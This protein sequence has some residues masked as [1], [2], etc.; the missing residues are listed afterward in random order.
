MDASSLKFRWRQY[1]NWLG[2]FLFGIRHWWSDTQ[3]PGREHFANSSRSAVA[4]RMACLAL[5]SGPVLFCNLSYPLL[6]PDE[7]RN[8]QI[9]LEMFAS[10]DPIVPT[11]NG[12]PYLHKPPLLH[13]LISAS[14][15]QFGVTEWSARL[16]IAVAAL[17]AVLATYWFGRLAVGG[18][19][20]WLGAALLLITG[21]FVLAGRFLL[22]DAV[23]TLFTTSG[24]LA[25]QVGAT[26]GHRRLRWWIFAGLA[27]G[28][29]I[30]AK[31]PIAL[32]LVVPPLALATL[33]M[34]QT[35]TVR[36][37]E[38][39]LLVG[40]ALAVAAPWYV[41]VSLRHPEFLFDF[42][43]VQHLQRYTVAFDHAAPW[44]FYIPV[45][46]IGMLPAAALLPALFMFLF[47]R[48]NEIRAL[49][50]PQLGWLILAAGWVVLFFSLSSSK[51]PTYI[52]PAI[53]FLCLSLGRVLDFVLSP[54]AATSAALSSGFWNWMQRHFP[55][56][57]AVAVAAIG[58][59]GVVWDEALGRDT[60]GGETLNAVYA[61]TCIGFAVLALLHRLPK[62]TA[63]WSLVAAAALI[64][65]TGGFNDLY[66]EL[67][68]H[69]SR[70]LKARPDLA[71]ARQLSSR[72]N[73]PVV[74][75]GTLSESASF[76]LDDSGLQKYSRDQSAGL[77]DLAKRHPRVFVL[78]IPSNAA[79][80]QEALP[81]KCQ[82]IHLPGGRYL[83]E[84]NSQP[85][86]ADH[87]LAQHGES[88]S[89]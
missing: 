32:V 80:L 10:G 30:L 5:L 86:S 39:S 36:W 44:W 81:P 79:S 71:S 75:Y 68:E 25:A 16:P 88:R 69:R 43:F 33:L 48:Q 9:G 59:G 70:L 40:I 41:A 84:L 66:P 6:E 87:D 1:W 35:F 57:A 62:G 7:N 60:I 82:L 63:G 31:G 72:S 46:L 18:R 61:L 76:Y 4:L 20:A 29:G 8:A 55:R 2:Q 64:A 3:F 56:K 13:W 24:A 15:R 73:A 74:L 65:T 23:L 77:I 14:F 42:F 45:L 58:V 21:G 12:Q 83:Y 37:R 22:M 67:A 78:T 54:A 26:R 50:S 89:R 11:R 49:R 38:W 19:A 53:P 85:G 51:L 34:P 27:C 47:S 52:L 28:L 17:L